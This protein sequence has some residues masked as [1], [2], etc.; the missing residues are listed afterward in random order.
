MQI[1]L[2]T[3]KLRISR[4]R[5]TWILP[6][7]EHIWAYKSGPIQIR[8]DL[9][10]SKYEILKIKQR[11][12]ATKRAPTELKGHEGPS[13]SKDNC[14]EGQIPVLRSMGMYLCHAGQDHSHAGPPNYPKNRFKVVPEKGKLIPVRQLLDLARE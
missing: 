2:S 9:K 11:S 10:T 12:L 14:H 6:K 4:V 7:Y 8:V 5:K 3:N 1:F 13:K